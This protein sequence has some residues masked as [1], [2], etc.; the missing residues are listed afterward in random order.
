MKISEFNV[1]RGTIEVQKLRNQGQMKG[2]K[3]KVKS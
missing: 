3:K 2:N 1:P